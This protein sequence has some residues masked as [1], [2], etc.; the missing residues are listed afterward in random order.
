MASNK[1]VIRDGKLTKQGQGKRLIYIAI[2]HHVMQAKGDNKIWDWMCQI[3]WVKQKRDQSMTD[4]VFVLA[5]VY[6]WPLDSAAF[7]SFISVPLAF[8]VIKP[9]IRPSK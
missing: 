3:L 7:R 8:C 6:C 2:A 4:P 1:E 9:R 5:G